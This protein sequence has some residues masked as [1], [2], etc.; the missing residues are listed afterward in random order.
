MTSPNKNEVIMNKQKII[1]C[2][3][4][5]FF[6]CIFI[7]LSYLRYRNFHT[8]PFTRNGTKDAVLFLEKGNFNDH[9][10]EFVDTTQ[11]TID[12]VI[13]NPPFR[14]DFFTGTIKINYFLDGKIII[15]PVS[16]KHSIQTDGKM[17]RFFTAYP[18]MDKQGRQLSSNIRMRYF[19]SVDQT[20]EIIKLS[21]IENN[22]STEYWIVTETTDKK[23]AQ[24]ILEEFWRATANG[25]FVY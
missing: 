19:F 11:V 6:L 18:L 23:L 22:A 8:E 7:T 2:S 3:F 13:T 12:G 17:T 15:M 21:L 1:L 10:L 5:A 9:K 16:K 24:D 14:D 20:N 25:I 4:A